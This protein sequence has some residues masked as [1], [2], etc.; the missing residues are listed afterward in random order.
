MLAK[1]LNEAWKQMTKCQTE[2][3]YTEKEVVAQ[4]LDTLNAWNKDR[5]I[6]QCKEHLSYLMKVK[7]TVVRTS[8]NLQFW[9]NLYLSQLPLQNYLIFIMNTRNH[10]SEVDSESAI[11]L[12]KNLVC[13]SDVRTVTSLSEISNWLYHAKMDQAIV[14]LEYIDLMSFKT[15]LQQ[16]KEDM[17]DA[18]AKSTMYAESA[19]Q[20]GIRI[21][22]TTTVAHAI[23]HIRGNLSEAKYEDLFLLTALFPLGYDVNEKIFLHPLSICDLEYLHRELEEQSEEFYQMVHKPLMN[24]QSYLFHLAVKVCSSKNN[25]LDITE[26][27]IKSYLQYLEE[28]MQNELDPHVHQ[29]LHQ[30]NNDRI[31]LQSELEA[32]VKGMPEQLQQG[33]EESLKGGGMLSMAPGFMQYYPQKL[34]LQDA[35]LI[36]PETLECTDVEQL[37]IIIL[38]KIMMNDCRCRTVLFHPNCQESDSS[39]DESSSNE[40]ADKPLSDQ[41]VDG[42]L[43]G[44]HPMD[45]ILALL[46]CSDHFLRQELMAR[47]ST[48]QFAIPLLLPDP[49]TKTLTM[50]LWAMHSIVK[51]WMCADTKGGKAI[52][53]ENRI[54]DQPSPIISFF[55]FSNTTTQLSKS[56]VL[57]YVI[58]DSQQKHFLNFNCEGGGKK[59]F[60]VD[61]LVEVCWYLPAGRKDDPFPKFITFTN[62][63]G[64]AR[65]HRKQTKFLGQVSFMNFVILSATDLNDKAGIELLKQLAQ[66]PGGLV[67]MFHTRVKKAQEVELS[68]SIQHYH[69]IKIKGVSAAD[70]TSTIRDRICLKLTGS[71]QHFVKLSD[72]AEFAR[73]NGICVDEDDPECTKAKILATEMMNKLPVEMVIKDEIFPLQGK[74]LWYEWA[75]HDK[76]QHRHKE[77]SETIENYIAQKE[78]EKRMLR[79]KQLSVAETGKLFVHSF[80]SNLLDYQGNIRNYF[81]QW[82]KFLLDDDSRA[83]LSQLRSQYQEQR[84]CLR[85]LQTK[86][87]NESDAKGLESCKG[88]I[89]ELNGKMVNVSIGLEHVFRE[90][91]QIYEAIIE[92][93]DVSPQLSA[94]VLLLPQVAAELLVSGYPLELLDGDAAHVPI[95]WV[96]AVLNK[97]KEKVG[98]I[99]LIVLSVLGVQS[100]GKSTLLNTM[101]GVRFAV[102]AGR[103]TRGAFIQLIPLSETLKKQIN[104]DYLLVID[105]EGLRA[106][107]VSLLKIHDHDNELATFVIGLAS[108]TIINILGETPGDIQD[109]LPTAVHAFI[110][111]KHVN[112]NPSCQFVYQNVGALMAN[113]KGMTGRDEFRKKLDEMTK[114]AAEQERWEMFSDVIEYR[115]EPSFFSSL[116]DGN[117]PMA[118]INRQYIKNAQ[119]LKSSLIKD[120]EMKGVHCSLSAFKT[121]IEDLWEALLYENFIFSYKN[122][123][124]TTA[125]KHLDVTFSQWSW[126]FRK[127][128]LEWEHKSENAIKSTKLQELP[129]LEPDLIYKDL[130][131]QVNKIHEALFKEMEKFFQEDKQ[132]HIL[133]Q[134]KGHTEGRLFRLKEER[135]SHGKQYCESIISGRQAVGKAAGMKQKY[136]DMV[137]REVKQLASKQEGE[138]SE[139][140][141]NEKFEIEWNRWM[142]NF[143]SRQENQNAPDIEKCL[144][145]HLKN[146]F[147]THHSLLLEQHKHRSLRARAKEPLM[148]RVDTKSHISAGILSTLSNMLPWKKQFHH[149]TAETLTS[150]FLAKAQHYLDNKKNKNFN[151][152]FSEELLMLLRQSIEQAE[153]HHKEFTFTPQYRVDIA[154]TV[155][156]YA[157]NVFEKMAENFRKKNDP[158]EYLNREMKTSFLNLF[159]AQYRQ[160]AK[161]KTTAGNFCDVLAKCIEQ[162]LI[163]SLGSSIV[164][165]MKDKHNCFRDIMALRAKIL[166][167]LAEKRSFD[168]YVVYLTDVRFS[169]ETWTK[170]YTEQHCKSQDEQGKSRLTVLAEVKLQKLLTKVIKT[171]TQA[172]E[173]LI[174]SLNKEHLSGAL[175]GIPNTTDTDPDIPDVTVAAPDIKQWLSDFHDKLKKDLPLDLSEIQAVGA[176]ELKDFEFFTEELCRGLEK[177]AVEEFESLK[178]MG[179]WDRRPYDILSESLVG[180]CEQCPFCKEQCEYDKDHDESVQ[181]SAELHRPEC[182]GGYRWINSGE[183]VL[184]ICTSSVASEAKFRN[185]D[186]NWE[187]HPCKTYSDIYPSWSIHP[188][189]LQRASSYW[190]WFVA[191]YTREIVEYFKMEPTEIPS[192][193]KSLTWERV[194]KDLEILY[195]S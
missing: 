82:L 64:D 73:A 38:Q 44:V 179:S 69:K 31:G 29:V 185:R 45:G 144:E 142:K 13:P 129:K 61:G 1:T 95:L 71:E 119:T 183:M 167:D 41:R 192:T 122:T 115:D 48:C 133:I 72:C 180:C 189:T 109:I 178:D 195:K 163:G 25:D 8:R 12:M 170:H 65:K 49:S 5:D 194:K 162:S 36:H 90:L 137:R 117:P 113:E 9:P 149:D 21:I 91:G 94:Q 76:E 16:V 56:M 102:S 55:R 47:L 148:F 93:R 42:E 160:C 150:L 58:S 89:E 62:L 101:F 159:K 32:L 190:K 174:E 173:S 98:D 118:P 19:E 147:S 99:K 7:E 141:L 104:C 37:P 151:T 3:M 80:I 83:K 68:E 124:E 157:L 53:K 108:I 79:K 43:R 34:T 24:L 121:R 166:Q 106:P 28:K 103:C 2:P 193:W 155:C 181:H 35:L 182:L 92:E 114:A 97:L 20:Q 146:S 40:A 177:L 75:N 84:Q 176:K 39:D 126:A 110:R 154:L 138:L 30:F 100:S 27:K 132:R 70:F 67:L 168:D 54:I 14:H 63:R 52:S 158:V 11:G 46:L 50:S 145:E 134:W 78:E 112:L 22:A 161:E 136:R 171:A 175:P 120:S 143:P 10:L 77:C 128:M 135:Q 131:E 139:D 74:S 127:Q 18:R 86:S 130:P 60:I 156:G 17:I 172:T 153:K 111:M 96:T 152:G 165:D 164:E 88:R 191:N 57:N 85:Q 186:T 116:W 184:T 23:N 81:L 15:V 4:L 6:S 123:L 188:N 187:F 33:K 26:S 66:A 107:E 140:E 125:Y 51:E 59:R 169:F 87:Q 105:T